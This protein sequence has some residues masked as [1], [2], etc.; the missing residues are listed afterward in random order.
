MS[1]TLH[2]T[3]ATVLDVPGAGLLFDPDETKTVEVL[4]TALVNAIQQGALDVI[5]QSQTAL[6]VVEENGETEFDL[7]IPWPGPDAMQVALNGLVL[8][9][10]EDYS[11][12]AADNRLVWLDEEI[13]LKTGDRIVLIGGAP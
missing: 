3:L 13:T 4:N 7:P 12:E 2:N 11:V 6:I 5:S 1:I 9:F 8:A 10:A